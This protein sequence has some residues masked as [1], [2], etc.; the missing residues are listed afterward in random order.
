M[1]FII[2]TCLYIAV[3]LW[4][5]CKPSRNSDN[6]STEN[7][8]G[9]STSIDNYFQSIPHF[10]GNV[11][12][13]QHGN[14][15]FSKSYGHANRQ[16]DVRNSPETKFNIGS[17]T[18]PFTAIA[19]LRLVEEGKLSFSDSV[20]QYLSDVPEHWQPL[21]IHQ[22]LSHTSGLMH[23]WDVLEDSII[24]FQKSSISNTL[25]WYYDQPLRFEPGTSFS[26]SGVGYLVLANI[27]EAVTNQSYDEYL[28]QLIY[29]PL[30]MTDTGPN[31]PEKVIPKLAQG[32]KIDS[33]E[34]QNTPQFYVPLLTGGGH[35][36]STAQDLLKF[37][38]ALANHSLLTKEMTETMYTPV[39][40]NYG[41]GWDIVK[42][43][44]LHVVFHTGFVPGYLSRLDRYPDYDL[45][46]IILTNYEANWSP[47]DSWDITNLIFEELQLKNE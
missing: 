28:K 5:S 8:P 26:Y 36:Y 35:L 15:L 46:L 11:L 20:G 42:N 39:L 31:N 38:R 37:E 30:Q 23:S 34:V 45:T 2:V 1:R 19:I 24:M 7:I 14:V 12:I 41:Y 44:T 21:T 13:A 16:F 43:D 6:V 32:Y 4:S 10:S 17:V 3:I 47:V 25:T 29:D 27:I 33:I 18:K 9:F 22:L 40:E